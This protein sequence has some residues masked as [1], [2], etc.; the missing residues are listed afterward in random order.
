M[1]FAADE[2]FDNTILRGLQRKIANLDIVRIQDTEVYQADDPTVLEWVAKENRILL[3][4]DAKTMPSFAYERI[5][6][7]EKMVGVFIVDDQMSLGKAIEELALVIGA[8]EMAE[9]ENL[10]LFIPMK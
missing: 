5:E 3:S 4:H 9:W 10:V 1:R 6:A 2:N 7:G 8:S